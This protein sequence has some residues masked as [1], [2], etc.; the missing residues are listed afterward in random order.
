MAEWQ[1]LEE[2]GSYIKLVVYL[3]YNIWD[4]IP[5]LSIKWSSVLSL[6]FETNSNRQASHLMYSQDFDFPLKGVFICLNI[7]Y[8]MLKVLPLRFEAAYR[9]EKGLFKAD[10]RQKHLCSRVFKMVR[11]RWLKCYWIKNSLDVVS[12]VFCNAVWHTG[13]FHCCTL[14]GE[15]ARERALKGMLQNKNLLNELIITTSSWT[16]QQAGLSCCDPSVL[17]SYNFLASNLKN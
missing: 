5:S 13:R 3:K 17:R 12:C 2:V 1:Q 7:L 11:R 9:N 16:H 8:I 10:I 15:Q 14:K 4:W 6:K